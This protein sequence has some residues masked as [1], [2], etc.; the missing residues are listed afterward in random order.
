M[1]PPPAARHQS[2]RSALNPTS[3]RSPHPCC[4]APR[5]TSVPTAA[6]VGATPNRGAAQE[7]WATPTRMPPGPTV[8]P[9]THISPQPPHTSPRP[10]PLLSGPTVDLSP[11]GCSSGG[12][13]EP[14]GGPGTGGPLPPACR[15]PPRLPRVSPAEAVGAPRNLGAA[16][17]SQ[18]GGRCSRIHLSLGSRRTARPGRRCA[19]GTG[20]PGFDP[21]RSSDGSASALVAA[22]TARRGPR[23]APVCR[24]P[25]PPSPSRCPSPRSRDRADPPTELTGAGPRAPAALPARGRPRAPGR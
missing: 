12:N 11:Y 6:A 4:R 7:P 17:Q 22:A 19:S 18:W 14:W 5:L 15:Q 25:P 20:W 23:R 16:G 2:S 21:G 24:F 10:P 8:G 1:G 9:Q 3:L 13:P